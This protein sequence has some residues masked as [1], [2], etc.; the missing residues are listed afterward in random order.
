VNQYLVVIELALAIW[1]AY[2]ASKLGASRGR[3]GGGMLDMGPV[4]WFFC[5]FL[6]FIVGFVCYVVNRPKLVAMNADAARQIAPFGYQN[7]QFGSQP[8][9]QFGG[10]PPSGYVGAPQF[11]GLPQPSSPG[12]GSF[13]PVQPRPAPP[14]GWYPDPGG[15]AMSRW[16]DGTTWTTHT[17]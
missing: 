13:A 1:V 11:A 15:T 6:C 3:L 5:C 14:A 7:Q 16:W 9:S 12:Q 2:D 4:A 8:S 10:P 17:S